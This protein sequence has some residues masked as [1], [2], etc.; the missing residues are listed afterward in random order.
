[1][2]N[3]LNIFNICEWIQRKKVKWKAHLQQMSTDQIQRAIIEFT[4]CETKSIGWTLKAVVGVSLYRPVLPV[5]NRKKDGFCFGI[6]FF[7]LKKIKWGAIK[8]SVHDWH[9]VYTESPYD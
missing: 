8:G 4:P 5:M 1:M 7:P 6:L 9:P 3:D 2:R